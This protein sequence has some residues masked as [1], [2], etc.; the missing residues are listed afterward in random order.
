MKWYWQWHPIAWPRRLFLRPES[1]RLYLVT[2]PSKQIQHNSF[3]GL[4]L[5]CIQVK[6]WWNLR[7]FSH[8]KSSSNNYILQ[9]EDFAS[10]LQTCNFLYL[11]VTGTTWHNTY[12]FILCDWLMVDVFTKYQVLHRIRI[13]SQVVLSHIWAFKK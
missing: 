9:I 7:N 11:E 3:L 2:P 13:S 10:G 4:S 5:L 6:F 1:R 8:T 12:I